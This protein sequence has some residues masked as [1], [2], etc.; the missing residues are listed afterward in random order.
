MMFGPTGSGKSHNMFG[1]AKQPWIVYM[2]LRDILGDDSSDND[3]RV[4]FGTIVQVTILEIYN[5]EIMIFCLVMVVLVLDLELGGL[6]AV[7]LRQGLK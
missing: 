7:H 3:D 6:K 1:C 4:G 5:E 2:S